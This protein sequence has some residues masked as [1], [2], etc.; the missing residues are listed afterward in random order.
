[1]ADFDYQAPDNHRKYAKLN[2]T[3]GGGSILGQGAKYAK[4]RVE[5][6]TIKKKKS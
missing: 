2:S 1:M 4:R 5:D 3:V 6:P